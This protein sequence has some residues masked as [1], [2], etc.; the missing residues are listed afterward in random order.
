MKNR[1]PEKFIEYLRMDINSFNELL[2]LIEP[3]ITKRNVVRAPIPAITRLE[4]CLRYLAS[5]DIMPSLSFAFRVGTNTVSKIVAETCQSIWNGL[6]EIVF[7]ECT[8]EIWIEKAKEYQDI[9]DFPN[10][11]DAIDGKH[12]GLQAPSHSGSTFYNYKNMHSIVLM[13]LADANYRFTVVDIGGEG[14]RSDG[15][16]FQHSELGRQLEY[17]SLNLPKASSIS[18]KGPKLPFI[19][20]GDEAFA[21]TPYMLRPYPR[22]KQRTYLVDIPPKDDDNCFQ[23]LRNPENCLEVIEHNILQT[24]SIVRD[25]FTQYFCTT[26]AIQQQWAKAYTNDY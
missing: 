10:C 11:V 23:K 26:G 17:I 12:I 20:V 1:D 6:K 8:E 25:L 4:I 7:P 18:E 5:G 9:W 3:H 15:G 24:G 19:I 13:A 2:K 14:R 16:I 21:L 22:K